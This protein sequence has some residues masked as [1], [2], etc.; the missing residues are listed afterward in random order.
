MKWGG[1]YSVEIRPK[2]KK[3]ERV[4]SNT[5]EIPEMLGNR[6]KHGPYL[7][8]TPKSGHAWGGQ[9][10]TKVIRIRRDFGK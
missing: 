5:E 4:F 1:V 10:A 2:P 8:L 6:T 7:L 9:S 3:G